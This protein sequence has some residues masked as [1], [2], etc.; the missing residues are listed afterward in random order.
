MGLHGSSWAAPVPSRLLVGH[1]DRKPGGEWPRW[2]LLP[3][4]LGVW[5]WTSFYPDS[6]KL[7]LLRGLSFC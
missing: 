4:L 7:V 1:G 2:F 3:F 6:A 5:K